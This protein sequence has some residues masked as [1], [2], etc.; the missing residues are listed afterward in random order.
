[1]WL[2]PAALAATDQLVSDRLAVGL[3]TD[4][5]LVSADSTLGI[6]WDP[7]GPEGPI[8]PGNDLLTPG[9]PFGV[10]ALRFD[11]VE[12]TMG[13]PYT[14]SAFTLDWAEG[15]STLQ[16]LSGTGGNEQVAIQVTAAL[17]LDADVLYWSVTLT[18]SAPLADVHVAHILDPDPD[19]ASYGDYG[20]DNTIGD[21]W[22]VGQGPYD[23][24]ALAIAAPGGL[25]RTCA[26]CTT[27]EGLE[28]GDTA[29]GY[30][31]TSLGVSVD[32]GTV[33]EPVTL[34]FAF[35]LDLDAAVAAERAVAAAENDDWDDDGAPRD[36][37]CDDLDPGRQVGVP[38]ACDETP[39]ADVDGDGFTPEGG[40][41]DD[42]N[43]LVFP[44]AG[45][46]PGVPDANCDGVADAAWSPDV[47]ADVE[48]TKETEP[49][50]GCAA[51][52]GRPNPL[53]LLLL[54]A[55][56]RSR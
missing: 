21:G 15:G 34:Q 49:T 22:I 10:W 25:A 14:T 35:A 43:P 37:D 30:A 55:L 13:C 29:E 31:D 41:C 5:S 42:A 16:W 23:G 1:M 45:V 40:D 24:V 20:T 18:P 52:P 8:P 4:G 54:L 56:R 11:G 26:F 19:F 51:A 32:H 33:A 7:D 44:G 6:V 12:Y 27:T 39:A 9:Y 50:G 47:P 17:P 46:Q 53:V 28:G 48:Q 38:G 36:T 3:C 2:I